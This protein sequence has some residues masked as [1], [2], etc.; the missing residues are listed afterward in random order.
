[1]KPLRITD[2]RKRALD[3]FGTPRRIVSLLPSETDNVRALGCLE[4]LVGR[5]D[6]CTAVGP[7]IASIPSIGGTKNLDVEAIVA[8]APD[9][10]LANQEENGRKGIE[11]LCQRGFP[12]FISF[13]CTVAAAVAHLARLARMLRVEESL[14]VKALVRR[15]YALVQRVAPAEDPVRVFAPIWADPLMTADGR[16]YLSSVIEAAGGV[17]VFH[18]RPRLY[19]LAADLGRAAALPEESVVERDTRYPRITVDEVVARDPELMIFP[20]EPHPFAEADIA[21]FRSLPVAA[22]RRNELHLIRGNDLLWQGARTIEGVE[23]IAAYVRAAR[24]A[25]TA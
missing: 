5:T 1:M 20:D 3:L 11:E 16:T 12:V 8:L 17:N 2:D 10:V 25:R 7:E 15:G 13:P 6:Y 14:A 23:R 18:D 21:P 19:P 22:A 4:R 9:L 24:A